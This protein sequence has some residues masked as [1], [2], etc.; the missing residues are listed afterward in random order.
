MEYIES[1][2][3]GYF[4]RY[5]NDDGLIEEEISAESYPDNIP[6]KAGYVFVDAEKRT[7]FSTI[8]GNIEDG[9]YGSLD[10]SFYLVKL[11]DCKPCQVSKG[12]ITNG[13]I[14]SA[15]RSEIEE[16]GDNTTKIWL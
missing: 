5:R 3:Y 10:D 1:N 16:C 4:A 2:G 6:V 9:Q 14:D 8:S 13:N 12:K 7:K 11:A 15:I